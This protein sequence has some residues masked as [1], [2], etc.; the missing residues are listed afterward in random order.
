LL[1]L[2][3]FEEA[4]ITPELFRDGNEGKVVGRTIR[5]GRLLQWRMEAAVV[6]LDHREFMMTG[7]RGTIFAG[8]RV[9]FV[10]WGRYG[11]GSF[12]VSL[13]RT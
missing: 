3:L 7:P 10:S 6:S 1:P 13:A 9:S 4:F 8:E 12:G 5:T 2:A 11:F